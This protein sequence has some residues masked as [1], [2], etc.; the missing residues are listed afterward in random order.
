MD[1]FY[2]FQFEIG[3]HY[4][5]VTP[6]LLCILLVSAARNCDRL[7]VIVFDNDTLQ[8]ARP[9]VSEGK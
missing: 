4:S 2:T 6:L 9:G 1:R 7:R 8:V 5:V 3:A